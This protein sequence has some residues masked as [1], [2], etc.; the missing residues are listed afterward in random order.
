MLQLLQK[1]V[2]L[3]I[4]RKNILLW[5][6]KIQYVDNFEVKNLK[7]STQKDSLDEPG[8]K[9]VSLSW[10]KMLP[11]KT[12]YQRNQSF[13]SNIVPQNDSLHARQLLV[14]VRAFLSLLSS[15]EVLIQAKLPSRHLSLYHPGSM[16]LN[17]D[18]QC[19]AYPLKSFGP[20][21]QL[22][23]LIWVLSETHN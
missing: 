14:E 5:I 19:R 2:R 7:G 13:F 18:W 21:D 12:A 11:S 16:L 20:N 23:T 15:A 17:D 3:E 10:Q 6:S 8:F 4:V 1:I 22:L 9:V